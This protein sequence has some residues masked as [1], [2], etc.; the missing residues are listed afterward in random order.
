M[1]RGR[2]G[3]EKKGRG[4]RFNRTVREEICGGLETRRCKRSLE[5]EISG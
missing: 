3:S 1:G 4:R 5:G 2:E